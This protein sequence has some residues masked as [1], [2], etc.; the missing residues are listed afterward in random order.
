MKLKKVE[1]KNKDDFIINVG[2]E[3]KQAS[4]TLLKNSI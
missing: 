3:V 4:D 2:G 1:R